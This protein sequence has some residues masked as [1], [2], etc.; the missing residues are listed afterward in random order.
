MRYLV[1]IKTKGVVDE[2]NVVKAAMKNFGDWAAEAGCRPEKQDILCGFFDV[3]TVEKRQAC[4]ASVERVIQHC[5]KVRRSG[6]QVAGGSSR[7]PHL[8]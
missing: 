1:H 3:S 2:G 4:M 8:P 5:A 7:G 6:S